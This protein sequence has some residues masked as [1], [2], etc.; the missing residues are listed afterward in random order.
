M[1]T[2]SFHSLIC[3]LFCFF[4]QFYFLSLCS[5]LSHVGLVPCVFPPLWLVPLFTCVFKCCPCSPFWLPCFLRVQILYY[6][7]LIDF[8]YDWLVSLD[9]AWTLTFAAFC[10]V[11]FDK[12]CLHVGPDT[13]VVTP[14]TW[15]QHLNNYYFSAWT[16][17]YIISAMF[18]SVME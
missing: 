17:T 1:S 2:S 15:G 3:I 11:V 10:F 5:A 4:F 7:L 8:C 9:F 13:P 16:C 14:S 18:L 12:P 6:S